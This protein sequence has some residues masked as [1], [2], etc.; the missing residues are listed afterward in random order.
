MIRLITPHTH[1][2]SHTSIA[3]ADLAVRRVTLLLHTYG[4]LE[5]VASI[6]L[7]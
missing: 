6:A 1:H 5:G 3:R 4:Y 2:S 7:G